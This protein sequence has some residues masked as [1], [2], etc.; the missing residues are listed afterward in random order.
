MSNAT[1]TETPRTM[2]AFKA[3]LDQLAMQNMLKTLGPSEGRMRAH[4][5]AKLAK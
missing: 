1:T 5:I 2:S 4:I 3:Y